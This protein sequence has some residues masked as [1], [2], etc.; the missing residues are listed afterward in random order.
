MKEIG[1]ELKQLRK[2]SGVDLEEE[3]DS[4]SLMASIP[5]NSTGDLTEPYSIGGG[6]YARAFPNSISYGAVFPWE[7]DLCH[8]ANEY[9][10]IDNLI[11]ASKIYAEA[12]YS[13]A[14]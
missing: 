5:R 13:L 4:G 8:Q 11:L 10:V 7:P 2:K 14:K 12:I 9:A 1:E 3:T 6:T